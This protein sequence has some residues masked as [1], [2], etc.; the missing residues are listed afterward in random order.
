MAARWAGGCR[1]SCSA[2]KKA[3]LVFAHGARDPAW[4]NPVEALAERL[5]RRMP[6][7]HVTCAYLE[8]MEPELHA[9]L[10]KLADA[11]YGEIVLLPVFWAAQGHVEGTLPRA[12]AALRERGI[13]VRVLP[14]LSEIPGLL[15][16]V[17][18]KANDVLSPGTP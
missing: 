17:S 4:A 5:R 9:L 13:T 14:V 1:A 10:D 11:G 3:V 8:R 15:D 6:D 16:F 18:T 2:V 7:A 12:A